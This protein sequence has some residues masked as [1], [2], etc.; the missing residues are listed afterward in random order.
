M[1]VSN[2]I[3]TFSN[4]LEEKSVFFVVTYTT[5]NQVKKFNDLLFSILNALEPNQIIRMHM[6]LHILHATHMM[7]SYQKVYAYTVEQMNFF[8]LLFIYTHFIHLF[9]Q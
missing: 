1:I 4:K 3:F 9:I 6:R 7:F 5:A 2:L 8:K